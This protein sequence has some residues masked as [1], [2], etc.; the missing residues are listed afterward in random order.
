MAIC[1]H[2]LCDLHANMDFVHRQ[3]I[4]YARAIVN[5]EM[6]SLFAVVLTENV[7]QG[8]DSTCSEVRVN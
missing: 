1:A 8:K 5:F 2:G 7:Q 3:A 4:A 6:K